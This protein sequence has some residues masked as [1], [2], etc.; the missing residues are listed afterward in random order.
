MCECVLVCVMVCLP[1][2]LFTNKR[3]KVVLDDTTVTVY[4]RPFGLKVLSK[5]CTVAELIRPLSLKLKTEVKCR[6]DPNQPVPL[7][8]HIGGVVYTSA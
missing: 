4:F 3:S 6:S 8:K 2:T 1:Q 7:L 5:Q